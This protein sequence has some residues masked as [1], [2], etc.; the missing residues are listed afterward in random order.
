MDYRPHLNYNQA[1][2]EPKDFEDAKRIVF[3][4]GLAETPHRWDVES[5]WNID[6]FREHNF[7]NENSIVIDW[8]V[9]VGRMSKVLID[10]FGCQVVGVDI[11]KSM[12][13]YATQYVNDTRFT[14]LTVD[15]FKNSNVMATNA[16][17]L[18]AFQ[19]SVYLEPDLEVIKQHLSPD[20]QLF[21]FEQ[22][23]PCIPTSG[24]FPWVIVA[25]VK[26]IDII[27]NY[28]SISTTGKFPKELNVP[29]N[30]NTWWGFFD[31]KKAT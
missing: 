1:F 13:E 27:L 6:L 29:E 28:F 2:F 23:E 3:G 12:L 19:H 30:A 16:I 7:I 8:G 24:E 17:A 10:T 31:K 9:G 4:H 20:G 14:G 15:Q 11:N 5:Q 18:W 21:V 25:V 26:N 22:N